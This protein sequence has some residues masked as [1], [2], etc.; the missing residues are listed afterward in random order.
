MKDK[1]KFQD[2]PS[3]K[4][5][6]FA[7]KATL[8]LESAITNKY[9][10]YKIVKSKKDDLFFVSLLTGSDNETNFNYLGTIF[11]RKD[12]KLTKKSKIT[13]TAD[14]FKAFDFFFKCLDKNFVHASLNVYHSGTCGRCGRILT[15]PESINRGLGEICANI[16]KL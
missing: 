6:V 16:K 11:N 14:S 7:G 2:T 10:T 12:F 3:I 9:F 8:T 4:E 5:F 15:T 13:T 1:V